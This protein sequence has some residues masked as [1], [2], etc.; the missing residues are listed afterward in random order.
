MNIRSNGLN[1]S[2]RA[3]D[4]E[5]LN[6][7]IPAFKKGTHVELTHELDFRVNYQ[8]SGIDITYFWRLTDD[9]GA[10][11]ETDEQT[12]LWYDNRFEWESETSSDV[13]V[14]S[15]RDNQAFAKIILDSAQSTVDRLKVEFGP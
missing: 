8:P 12:L 5:T 2:Y 10:V 11:V 4:R 15:Y 6:L 7:E 13:T 1:S 3:A 14:Y 9:Q